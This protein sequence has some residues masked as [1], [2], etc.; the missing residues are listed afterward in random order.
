MNYRNKLNIIA[1]ILIVVSR[2]AKK[3]QI[4]YQANLS[5]K[6]MTRYLDEIVSA[7]L[8]AFEPEQQRYILTEKGKRFQTAYRE[9]LK[10]RRRIKK[11]LDMVQR[12]RLFLEEMCKNEKKDR[13]AIKAT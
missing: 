4:M 1:D 2:N 11:H 5:Y 7:S 6:V 8:V 12:Q 3:T 9:Y 10:T 13:L